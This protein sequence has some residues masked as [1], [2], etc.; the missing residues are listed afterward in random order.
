MSSLSIKQFE[1][2]AAPEQGERTT[3]AV[4]PASV[5]CCRPTASLSPRSLSAS[6]RSAPRLAL[7][8]GRVPVPEYT[9][10]SV[11][12]ARRSLTVKHALTMTLGTD[13]DELTIP[14]TDP[15]T[16]RPR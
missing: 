10:L 7:A 8:A 12:P 16:A 2:H 15:R 11:D 9:D 5:C 1:T 3:A 4:Q 14:H 13:W 6:F